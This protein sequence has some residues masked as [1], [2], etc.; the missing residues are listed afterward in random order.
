ML[1]R[2]CDGSFWIRVLNDGGPL[3]HIKYAYGIKAIIIIIYIKNCR[4]I[5]TLF[6][7]KNCLQKQFLLLKHFLFVMGKKTNKHLFR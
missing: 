1:L 3:P 2:H 5:S 4:L 6:Y 7:S